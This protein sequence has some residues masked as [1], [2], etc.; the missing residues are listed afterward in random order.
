[1][2]VAHINITWTG[3]MYKHNNKRVVSNS[4]FK[5]TDLN[6][7]MGVEQTSSHWPDHLCKPNNKHVVSNSVFMHTGLNAY[8]GVDVEYNPLNAA[9]M[10]VN[11]WSPYE[12]DY[13]RAGY[14]SFY[15]LLILATYSLAET[16]SRIE[17]IFKYTPDV[18]EN[19]KAARTHRPP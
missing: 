10:L 6:T 17:N 19:E 15:Q 18:T 3:H 7:Y 8:V 4:L 9:S 1:M 5:H 13:P 14:L 2:G 12:A 16:P 11:C